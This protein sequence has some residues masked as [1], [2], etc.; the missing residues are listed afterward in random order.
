M[1]LI[2][3]LLLLI[4]FKSY[5]QYPFEKYPAIK[6]DSVKIVNH[7]TEYHDGFLATHKKGFRRVAAYK[8][9]RLVFLCDSDTLKDG[10]NALLYHNS[11]IIKRMTL[12]VSMDN[13]GFD[14]PV[15]IGDIDGNGLPDF[16]ITIEN[17]GN[18]FAASYATKIYLF[19]QGKDIFKMIS[20]M[21]LFSN[22]ER[23]FNNDGNYEIIGEQ[24]QTY[25]HQAYFIFN[26]YNF[27][28]GKIVNVSKNFGFPTAVKYLYNP[29]YKITHEIPEKY[30]LRFAAKYPDEY[31]THD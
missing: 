28:G 25:K 24:Y 17:S 11:R 16:K 26:L 21:D 29:T 7:G 18:G 10:S 23:D 31:R 15:Y 27:K 9:Y 22:K 6:F 8:G 30:L 14:L 1:K 3:A 20:F 2:C 13:D 5:T 19:N 4:S 12:S